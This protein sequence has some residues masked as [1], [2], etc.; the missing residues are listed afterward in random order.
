MKKII[1][2]VLI[3]FVF[4]SN[5]YAANEPKLRA[6]NL[7]IDEKRAGV[8][9]VRAFNIHIDEKRSG[10]PRLRALNIGTR[11]SGLRIKSDFVLA[12]NASLR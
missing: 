1:L 2:S 8:P 12:S 6:L 9:R 5:G 4:M 3:I 11:E 10:V 7:H